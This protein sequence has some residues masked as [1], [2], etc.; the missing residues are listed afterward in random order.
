MVLPESD[1]IIG[2]SV[3]GRG[4][5]LARLAR[6]FDE[7]PAFVAVVGPAHVGKSRVAAR[8][9][10]TRPG[11]RLVALDHD[12]R[13]A[14]DEGMHALESEARA[15]TPA[16]VVLDD[17]DGLAEL[18]ADGSFVRP[19][20]VPL[21]V[22]SREAIPGAELVEL[23]PIALVDV[24]RF[25]ELSAF[26]NTAIALLDGR[27][28]AAAKT[29]LVAAVRA[30]EDLHQSDLLA[31]AQ[32]LLAATEASLG[33]L[34]GAEALSA[35]ASSAGESSADVLAGFV[36]LA[37]AAAARSAGRRDD[38]TRALDRARAH[39]VAPPDGLSPRA[40]QRHEFALYRLR[41]A[42]GAET[43]AQVDAPVYRFG[44]GVAW[45]RV[46][47]ADAIDL[48]RRPQLRRVLE[49]LLV[50]RQ[51]AVG[52]ALSVDELF[53]RSWAGEKI[54]EASRANRVRVAIAALRGYGLRDLIEL[55]EGGYRLAPGAPI[56][57]DE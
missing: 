48:E 17:A 39:L 15:A 28:V 5:E 57:V 25:G 21:L 1:A 55:H 43:L 23:G 6:T 36:D 46:H 24:I 50:E 30:A 53:A 18:V 14:I 7:G 13:G 47:D 52:A 2:A 31:F 51:R 11:A 16:I 20:R 9:A 29:R 19:P 4:L 22:T 45:V 40:R 33:D 42:V 54:A 12:A 34:A 35:R 44:A 38:A 49:A 41:A 37:Q 10:A 56:V 32:A 26:I 27:D 8:F 3:V